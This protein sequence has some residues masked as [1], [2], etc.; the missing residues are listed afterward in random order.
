MK[1]EELTAL[2]V[3]EDAIDKIMQI[4]GADI[5]KHKKA[6][7]TAR[8]EAKTLKNQL[9]EANGKLEKIGDPAADL[10]T[11]RQEA[12]DWKQKYETMQTEQAEAERKRMYDEA[13]AASLGDV[14]FSSESAKKA[15]L[16]DAAAKNLPVDNGRLLGFADFL[17][18]Y[19]ES[20]P[21]AFAPEKP[22][23]GLVVDSAA[24]GGSG[25]GAAFDFGF[26]PIR[27]TNK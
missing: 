14:A 12:A 16:A 23:P 22:T 7:E 18:G 27:N 6:A 26:S 20:D 3:P 5:E 25:G 8:G 4:N 24:G 19:R 13:L 17:K 9:A 2:H 10:E 11:A 21:G 15:F 1:R